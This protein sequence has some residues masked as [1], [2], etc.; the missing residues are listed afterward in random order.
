MGF[1]TVEWS[2]GARYQGEWQNGQPN[3]KGK[4]F[5]ENGDTYEGDW[6]DDQASG[7]GCWVTSTKTYLGEWLN[8][9]YH[10]QGEEKWQ[11]G[12]SF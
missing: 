8:D 1:G 11:D 5:L 3:G 7:F 9:V 2:D 12:S 4:L 10:G 6:K